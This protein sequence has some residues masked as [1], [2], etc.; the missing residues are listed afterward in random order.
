MEAEREETAMALISCP[1][2]G[3]EISSDS[4]S[5]PHCGKRIKGNGVEGIVSD[6]GRIM[7]VMFAIII[8]VALVIGLVTSIVSCSGAML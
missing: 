1:E 8:P 2:C 5:C 7:G 4:A 3:R 6:G